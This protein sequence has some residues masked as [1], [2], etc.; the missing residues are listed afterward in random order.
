VTP[1]GEGKVIDVIPLS[2]K[3]VVLLDSDEDKHIVATFERD[4]LQPWEELEALKHRQG[5]ATDTR[6]RHHL[7]RART[8]RSRATQK[9]GEGIVSMGSSPRIC[10]IWAG[11]NTGDVHIG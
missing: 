1:R 5:P 11:Q 6:R 9:A 4:E 10:R 3:V 8:D 7:R 2:A